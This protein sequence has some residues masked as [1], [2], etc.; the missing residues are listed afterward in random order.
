[1]PKFKD[2]TGK[3]F[4]YWEVEGFSTFDRKHNA[5][6]VCRCSLCGDRYDVYSLNLQSGHSTKCRRC[7]LLERRY[8]Y[9]RTI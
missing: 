1:M 7:A 6:F 5:K 3:T 4:G 2:L 9:A 8:G